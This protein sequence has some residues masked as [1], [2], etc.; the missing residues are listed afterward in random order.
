MAVASSRHAASW[1]GRASIIVVH[2]RQV[3]MHSEYEVNGARPPKPRI[4]GCGVESQ[5]FYRAIDEQGKPALPQLNT[6]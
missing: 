1:G 6:A 3:V 2:R 4:Q 5:R